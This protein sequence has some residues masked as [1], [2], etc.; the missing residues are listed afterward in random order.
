M[1]TLETYFDYV[2]LPILAISVMLVFIR[3]FKGP[4]VVD[5]VIALDLI[6]TIGIGIITVYSIR[7]NQ[8]V[9]LDVAIILALI[10]FLG[11]VAFAY[12]IEKQKD[13]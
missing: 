12:Y 4:S 6:I 11:T 13:D 5:R 2:I 7:S 8:K 3:L 1:I 9:L 10:A